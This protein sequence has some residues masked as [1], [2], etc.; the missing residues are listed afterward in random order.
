MS[1]DP[2]SAVLNPT[3]DRSRRRSLLEQGLLCLQTTAGLTVGT[4]L[5]ALGVRTVR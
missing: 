2:R 5:K 1:R 3:N 4:Q